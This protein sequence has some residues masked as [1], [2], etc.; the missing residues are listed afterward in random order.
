MDISYILLIR[1]SV[2]GHWGF[3]LWGYYECYYY[4]H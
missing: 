1:V 4:G 2:D 3:P